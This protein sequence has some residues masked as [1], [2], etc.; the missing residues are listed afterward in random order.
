[1]TEHQTSSSDD[2]GTSEPSSHESGSTVSRPASAAQE[3]HAQS[4]DLTA[5]REAITKS[6]RFRWQWNGKLLAV[7][8]VLTIVVLTAATASYFYHSKTTAST[9]LDLANA[10]EQEQNY[11]DQSKWLRRYS[12]LVPDDL[13]TTYQMAIAADKAADQE[14]RETRGQRIDQA[15]RSLSGAIG[16]IGSE[17]DERVADLRVRLINRLVQLGG[18]W[19]REAERQIGELDAP[20][21]DAQ[22]MTFLAL[23]LAGEIAD[24]SY[25]LR[26]PQ[27]IA[28]I[29]DYW[30][31][32]ANQPATFVLGSALR[33]NPKNLDLITHFLFTRVEKAEP[34]RGYQGG[35]TL[36]AKEIA[37][38]EEQAVQT[39]RDTPTS[40]SQL[41]YYRYL[42]SKGDEDAAKSVVHGAAV[43]AR[44]RLEAAALE[45]ASEDTGVGSSSESSDGSQSSLV[46]ANPM[47]TAYWDFLAIY[48]D[49]R[50]N[51]ASDAEKA[52][53]QYAFLSEIDVPSIPNPLLESVAF[54]YGKLLVNL[55]RSDE[56]LEIWQAAAEDI[57]ENG[58]VLPRAIATIY[59]NR[60]DWD[61]AEEMTQQLSDAI[62]ASEVRL[63]RI[64]EAQLARSERIVQARQLAAARWQLNVLKSYLAA[65]QGDEVKAIDLLRNAVNSD[66]DITPK[67]RIDALVH[68]GGYYANQGMWDNSAVALEKAVTLDP[69]NANLRKLTADAWAR[70]GNQL[71]SVRQL[72]LID[73]SGSLAGEVS[74]MESR[75]N[76]QLQLPPQQRNFH[77]VHAVAS[78]LQQQLEQRLETADELSEAEQTILRSSLH[79][80][81]AFELTIPPDDVTAED[82]LKS[83][84][85]ARRI[86]ELA[87]EN[88]DE[89]NLQ[90]LAA[91]RL[92]HAG[93]KEEAMAAL[94]RLA[95]VADPG[96]H[97]EAV[98][99]AR[100]LSAMGQYRDAATL[101]M[102]K[103]QSD[104]ASADSE[105]D[106]QAN[107]TLLRDASMFASRGQDNELAY[108]ALASID[109]EQ[110]NLQTLSVI[111]QLAR[112]LPEGSSSL[113]LDGKSVSADDLYR[114]WF[115]LLK[116]REGD[117]GT[118]W[119]YLKASELLGE[120]Q[121]SSQPM[122]SD[123]PKLVEARRLTNA[124]VSLRPRWG[125]AIALQGRISA[126][127]GD[128][129]TAVSQLQRAI[130][131]GSNGL[132]TRQAL[133]QQLIALG[134]TAE[135]EQEIR[136]AELSVTGQ[137][138]RF[139][140]TRI[141]LALRQ[142]D[143]SKSMQVAKEAAASRPDDV[144]AQ[145][146]VAA[147]GTTAIANVTDLDR[148]DEL[149]EQITSAIAR[150]E[151]LA[152]S[153]D[154]RVIAAN[155][156]LAIARDD[157][158]AVDAVIETIQSSNV[159]ESA[160]NQL[161][162]Q[163]YVAQEDYE[164]ALTF[165]IKADQLDP[166]SESQLRLAEIYRR[167]ERPEEETHA[168][169]VALQ[170]EPSNDRLRN[171]LAQKMVAR[172][173]EGDPVDW[174]AVGDLL[175]G[176]G[177]AASNQLMHA[178]LLG[179]EAMRELNS[180]ASSE[181]AQLRLS[182]SITILRDLVKDQR[183]DWKTPAR[184][185]AT[186]LRQ[187]PHVLED[188]SKPEL[189]RIHTE[190]R[191]LYQQ[192]I[193]DG[194]VEASD[195]Y[196]YASYLLNE[197]D[198]SDDAKINNLI[199]KLNSLAGSS[200]EA[201]EL[202]VRFA[203][204]QGKRDQTA[205]VVAVWANRGLDRLSSNASPEDEQA[206]V[207]GL[208]VMGA[209]GNALRNLGFSE[210]SLAWFER[211]Y[212]EHPTR[213]LGP[214]VVALG[215]AEELEKAVQACAD[216]FNEHHDA[217][218]ATLLVEVLLNFEDRSKQAE[219][220]AAH[221]E[222]LDDAG[223]RFKDNA[224]FLEGLG[225]LRM[226][227]G[228]YDKA[229]D[230][231]VRVLKINPDSIRS[232]NNLAMSYSEIPE[233]ASKGLAPIN[234]ALR[235][236]NQNPEL[237]DTKGVVLMAS[238]RLADAEATFADAFSASREPRHLFHV[239]VAQL[240]QQ[241]DSQAARNWKKLDLDKLDP[242]GLTASERETLEEL[243]TKFEASS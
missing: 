12:M 107:A 176:S 84:E 117:S 159:P 168:L 220:T 59:I 177:G 116:E 19:N 206:A 86:D 208:M 71:N 209:A 10:A 108:E 24:G 216:H 38:I 69:E 57:G 154:P 191:S 78:Q 221:Q 225:T 46:T 217:Q 180:D 4:P 202:S 231:F 22:A 204:R 161:L 181:E 72:D 36:P 28:K 21:N 115:G 44:E 182:Q 149:T 236:T 54:E 136:N 131:S 6:R 166:T 23:A 103:A 104:D 200:V 32:L 147:T 42:Q 91:E 185:L 124:I 30:G 150:A 194:S 190:V 146:V 239:I 50:L 95:K 153:D 3:T 189:A 122:E 235:L 237:L 119:R 27:T 227:E 99:R 173:A 193:N 7:T 43:P 129:D 143:Y 172:S 88:L 111:T 207:R 169:Q 61:A 123:N 9:F 130:A 74:E 135:A 56:A 81:E 242:T 158:E 8:A 234:S 18:P 76:F 218:S 114:H 140:A 1:M 198:S 85:L 214:Y 83:A 105:A 205:E 219:L 203:D 96:S 126:L 215:Q 165:L 20:E 162:S 29:D 75:F 240:N 188:L 157:S 195:V 243:K 151:E 179:S 47:P 77:E 49:A 100:T 66:V 13:D 125:D 233:L 109:E 192:L 68:L 89:A 196:Q 164:Q 223:E 11:E 48:D 211:A 132:Q 98:A 63:S 31:W 113:T 156:R 34:F 241:K 145:L 17:D 152:S 201:L 82:H 134:R 16:Q 139:S 226:A 175:A 155:L 35:A 238:G 39:L 93:L 90:A 37:A 228:Q 137:S 170:R 5:T 183:G 92:A 138:D 53:Q 210:D 87:Q 14:D 70:S 40:H 101:L 121:E 118:F 144:N 73:S 142:G 64:T 33:E 197:K 148:R 55:D 167:L 199:E 230:C 187:E 160:Q 178:I 62:D 60:A 222:M 45:G 112:T 52:L 58:I 15:R 213:A 79:Y 106:K 2:E 26:D 133:W 163:A 80:V 110:R 25:A 128:A 229:V 51:Q 232:M 67:D 65:G 94:D 171:M 186:L 184:Y 141:S 224:A 102:E 127:A 97:S 174:Q 41:V 120:L 212:R